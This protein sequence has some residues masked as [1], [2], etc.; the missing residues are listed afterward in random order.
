MTAALQTV[1]DQ[2][3]SASASKTPLRIRGGGTKDFYADKLAGQVL[4]MTALSGI[5]SY[6]PS[7]LV[8][9]TPVTFVTI[10]I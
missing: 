8:L 7:E 2:I 3:R 10:T 5:V 1:I 6:E 4:D 9:K